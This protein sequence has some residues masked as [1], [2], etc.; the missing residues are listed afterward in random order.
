VSTV[1]SVLL[2]ADAVH[3]LTAGAATRRAAEGNPAAVIRVPWSPEDPAAMV[4]ALQATGAT[5]SGLVV[6]VGLAFLEVA[7]PGLPPIDAA[8]KRAV[9]WRDADRYFP[10]TD[11]AAV[12]AV[13]DVALA[14]S[15]R[16][17]LSWVQALRALAPVCA[18]VT[19]PQVAARVRSGT[20]SLP[21]GP[22]ERGVLSASHG[23][24]QSVRRAPH[25]ALPGGES[26]PDLTSALLN[27]ALAWRDIT[28]DQ[29][30]LDPTLVAD[31][32]LAHRQRWTLSIAVAVA[33]VLLLLVSA[34]HRRDAE[35]ASM[36]ARAAILAQQA[37]PALRAEA[38]RNR[39]R[40]ELALLADAQARQHAPDAPL[41]VLAHVG[42]VLPRDAFV[43]RLEWDGQQWRMEGTADNAPRLVPLLDGDQ[44]FRDVRI[45]A[46]S[47]RF[48]DAGRPRESFA[49]TFRMRDGDLAR[50]ARAIGT[51]GAVGSVGAPGERDDTP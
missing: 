41:V 36:T 19:A 26:A 40:D 6:V 20:L 22:G 8:A 47:Q 1:W 45:A 33:A 25:A 51:S 50:G 32:Q 13:E 3:V 37:E 23:L 49:I 39:A 9:L 10:L 16:Q 38:R 43:Q 29:Q 34:D 12:V 17:L 4:Q 30:L 28:P 48:L 15:A 11:A 27:E 46:A 7:Q 35:H 21:A 42:R 18:I 5:P 14:M 44:H 24:V 2:E 31:A